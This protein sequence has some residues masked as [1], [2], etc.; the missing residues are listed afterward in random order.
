MPVWRGGGGWAG[1]P[2]R[3]HIHT[4][5]AVRFSLHR[6]HT[7]CVMATIVSDKEVF[8][9]F[10]QDSWK[11]Y[12]RS[13]VQFGGGGA[14]EGGLERVGVGKGRKRGEGDII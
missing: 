14:G 8:A 9:Q 4:Q 10:N 11:A 5:G 3:C 13:W 7:S 2:V 6:E 12:K 1:W